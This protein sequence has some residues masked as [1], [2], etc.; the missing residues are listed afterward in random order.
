MAVLSSC[1]GEMVPESQIFIVAQAYD[2]ETKSL[3]GGSAIENRI[4][5]VTLAAYSRGKLYRSTYTSLSGAASV[6]MK[7]ENGET[8]S[9]YALANTGD[10]RSLFPE[11]ESDIPSLEYRLTSYDT[12]PNSVLNLGIP[13]AGTAVMRSGVGASI[14]VKRLLAKVSVRV[15]CEWPGAG[16]RLGQ[17]GNMNGRLL[18]FGESAMQHIADAF[19][20][21]PESH[22]ASGGASAEMVFYVPENLQGDVS[23]ILSPE[24]KSHEENASVNALRNC[25]TYLE[26]EVEGSGLYSGEIRYRSYL[27]GNSRD[28]F[29]IVRNC[30]YNWT[31]TYG[32]DGLGESC[33]KRD[34]DM[35]DLR[36]LNVEGPLYVFP[37]ESISLKDYVTT[38][39][40]LS[41]IG[42]SLGPDYLRED[43]AGEVVNPANLSGISFTADDSFSAPSYGNRTVSIFPLANPQ[44][45]LGGN[46]KAYMADEDIA[47][48]STLSGKYFVTPG[49]QTSGE[50][51]YFVSYY[52][53]DIPGSATVHLKGKAGSRW[54]LSADVNSSILG[55]TGKEFDQIRFSP[56]STTLPGDYPVTVTTRDGSSASAQGHVNDTRSIRW[57]DRST[58]VPS[59]NGFLGYRFLSENKIVVI[60]SSAGGYATA[61]GTRFTAQNSP[62]AFIAGDRSAKIS[63]LSSRYK[64][65]PFEGNL[66]LG[67]N[68]S[69]RIIISPDS[70]FQTGTI[71][72]N[73][74]N[75][76][77]T[78][79]ILSIAPSLS[80]NLSDGTTYTIRV[81]AKNGYDFATSH[82][83]EAKVRAGSGT[84]RELA[85]I[86]AI[87]KVDVGATVTLGARFHTFTVSGDTLT[88]DSSVLLL[89]TMS[90]LTWL[91]AP[92]GIFTATEPGNYRVMASYNY[93]GRLYTAYADIEVTSSD[94]DIDSGWEG[95]EHIVLD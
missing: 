50:V 55:D 39:M 6:P 10:S 11:Y 35:D 29:D 19:S 66:L 73:V 43:M 16:V 68:Y 95:S 75:G 76:V 48:R 15:S 83:I 74:L 47:W 63:D 14:T 87:S 5:G 91:N 67:S 9:L 94:V 18:P 81:E 28:N 25:L 46:M 77:L 42:W 80:A 49:R 86:P 54:T 17:I 69:D 24:G 56:P 88:E 78:S 84:F 20:F 27:G 79:G 12:G 90:N 53:D 82:S 71:S 85:L 36:E 92:R 59:G 4:S 7:L 1:M 51:D 58:A 32:E 34:N 64:G 26:V 61:G 62:L 3:L 38:N 22:V 13:M 60:L 23:G 45:W 41:R 65:V 37:G 93:S 2:G 70:P 8:Y 44:P 30:T 21:R 31:I 33:W 52:D 72:S 40:D 89:P 57:L